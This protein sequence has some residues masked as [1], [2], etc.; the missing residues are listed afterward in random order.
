MSSSGAPI[1]VQCCCPASHHRG[2]LH[3][4]CA[5]PSRG[6]LGERTPATV[7][8]WVSPPVHLQLPGHPACCP[9]STTQT[10]TWHGNGFPTP[11]T[12]AQGKQGLDRESHQCL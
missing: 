5:S 11:E 4:Q 2:H 6:E 1:P 12:F 8:W 7:L 10:Y 9:E 3:L